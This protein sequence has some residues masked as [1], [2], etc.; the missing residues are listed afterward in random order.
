MPIAVFGYPQKLLIQERL[1]LSE[2]AN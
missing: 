2:Q 1:N